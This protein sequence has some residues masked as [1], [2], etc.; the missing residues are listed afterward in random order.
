MTRSDCHIQPM[1][2]LGNVQSFGSVTEQCG[3]TLRVEVVTRK[4]RP[5]D[6]LTGIA[7]KEDIVFAG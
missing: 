5:D 3:G 7:G 1:L 6:T 4:K 2:H